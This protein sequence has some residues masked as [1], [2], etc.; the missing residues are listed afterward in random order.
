[1]KI[2]I[3]L[4]AMGFCG[5]AHAEIGDISCQ[6]EYRIVTK[7]GIKDEVTKPMVASSG[8]ARSVHFEVEL[9]GRTFSLS[10]DPVNDDFIV[11]Q[12]WGA[13]Y[14]EGVLSTTSFNSDGRLQIS[15]VDTYTWFDPADANLPVEK[16]K[17]PKGL[18]GSRI[19]KLVCNKILASQFPNQ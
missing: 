15:T 9:N 13:D 12:N 10:G 16:K 4:L 17:Y 18:I 19:F 6:A 8:S 1:M 7:D 14:T 5:F 11:S 2:L 3:M